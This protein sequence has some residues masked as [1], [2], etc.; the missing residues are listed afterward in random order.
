MKKKSY[1]DKDNVITEGMLD[2]FAKMLKVFSGGK[3]QFSKDELKML[4]NKKFLKQLGS[5]NSFMKQSQNRLIQ[6]YKDMGLDPPD[7]LLKKKW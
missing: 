7:E 3:T 2:I 4:K 1:M 6:Q 5:F